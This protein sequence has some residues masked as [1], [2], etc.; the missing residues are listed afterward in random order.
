MIRTIY[1]SASAGDLTA[2]DLSDILNSARRNNERDNIT[3]M[4]IYHR[5]R[6]FQVIEGDEA[7]VMACLDRIGADPRHLGVRILRTEAVDERI[8]GRW[9]MGYAEVAELQAEAR[10]SVFALAQMVELSAR[11]AVP[12]E[13]LDTILRNFL[14][15]VGATHLT[16][17][18]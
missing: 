14:L 8:F 9:R 13:T 16:K 17:A 6:F 3:G 1:T 18:N 4:L 10:D 7:N 11:G 5:N 15:S 12:D 2:A